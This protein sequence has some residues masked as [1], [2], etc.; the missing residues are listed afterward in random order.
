MYIGI[1][2]LGNG[3]VDMSLNF[4]HFIQ[5]IPN[6]PVHPKDF[7]L[8]NPAK[9]NTTARLKLQKLEIRAVRT[10][11]EALQRLRPW[12]ARNGWEFQPEKN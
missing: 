7:N 10:R 5:F 6:P 8:K 11:R 1:I 9:S 4:I 3:N 12:M 2:L